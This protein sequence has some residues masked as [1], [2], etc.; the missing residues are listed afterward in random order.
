MC[1]AVKAE[2]MMK[3]RYEE[4]KMRDAEGMHIEPRKIIMSRSILGHGNAVEERELQIKLKERE[5]RRTERNS[6]R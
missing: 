6:F 1:C 3:L 5:Y 2:K 4:E